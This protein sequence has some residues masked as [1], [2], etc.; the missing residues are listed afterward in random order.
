VYLPRV[1][2]VANYHDWLADGFADLQTWQRHQQQLGEILSYCRD[3]Q[4]T[5]RIVL[6]PFL[7]TSGDRFKTPT[8]HATLRRFFEANGV[9]VVDFHTVTK[10]IPPEELI[11]NRQDAHPNERAHALFA[12]AIWE[13]FYKSPDASGH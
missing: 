8:L 4:T 9:P 6:L 12:E 7:R 11:V 2:T 10:D 3:H 13:S 5:L 1:P